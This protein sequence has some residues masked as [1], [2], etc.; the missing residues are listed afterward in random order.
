MYADMY[1]ISLSESEISDSGW[2]FLVSSIYLQITIFL[3]S[4]LMIELI[5]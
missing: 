1:Y 4:F 5:V 2:F 3:S